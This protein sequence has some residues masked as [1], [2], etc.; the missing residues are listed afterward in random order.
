VKVFDVDMAWEQ[1]KNGFLNNWVILVGFG[2]VPVLLSLVVSFYTDEQLE[3][4]MPDV[5]E[6]ISKGVESGFGSNLGM[7][8]SGSIESFKD[9]IKSALSEADINLLKE[10]ASMAGLV[11]LG[12]YLIYLVFSIGLIKA[13]INIMKGNIATITE[14]L[15]SV[16][17]YFKILGVNIVV[18]G[19]GMITYMLIVGLVGPT[20]DPIDGVVGWGWMTWLLSGLIA[21]L[22]LM[23]WFYFTMFTS[24]FILSQSGVIESITNSIKLVKENFGATVK[25]S[26][27]VW[28]IGMVGSWVPI[29]GLVG[30]YTPVIVLF[31]C[32]FFIKMTGISKKEETL[33]IED[34]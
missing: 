12:F 22:P 16:E 28:L 5:G 4:L 19:T 9:D 17:E 3:V 30:I 24:Y 18:I 11:M 7:P 33:I 32:Y 26:I 34:Y 20:T 27:V 31:Y 14:S 23:M 15:P 1:V 10:E 13:G 29:P 6:K 25:L 8:G 2:M 21:M